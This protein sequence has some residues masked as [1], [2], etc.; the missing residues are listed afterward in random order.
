MF[1]L[2]PGGGVWPQKCE[3]RPL[4]FAQKCL[5]NAE[6]TVSQSQN[7]KMFLESIS[8]AFSVFAHG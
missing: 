6:N 7:S 3:F 2:G 8:L 5:Q 4:D 1:G